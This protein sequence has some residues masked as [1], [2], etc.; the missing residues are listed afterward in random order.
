MASA[1]IRTSDSGGASQAAAAKK[2]KISVDNDQ[3]KKKFKKLSLD[4]RPS[5]SPG[6]DKFKSKKFKN[7]EEESSKI[8]KINKG[9]FG[10]S[11]DHGAEKKKNKVHRRSPSPEPRKAPKQSPF[12]LLLEHYVDDDWQFMVSAFFLENHNKKETPQLRHTLLDFFA[13]FP[14]PEDL[15]KSGWIAVSAFL[16]PKGYKDEFSRHVTRYTFDYVTNMQESRG[17]RARAHELAG[18]TDYAHYCY[19]IYVLKEYQVGGKLDYDTMVY[20]DWLLN[21]S[22]VQ[23][24]FSRG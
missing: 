9:S 1:P 4:D 12:D 7:R 10:S 2:R 14:R 19:R 11:K 24:F 18:T 5:S 8:S 23:A 3:P 15:H 6:G 13:R 17:S 20:R 16:K 21:R 22:R